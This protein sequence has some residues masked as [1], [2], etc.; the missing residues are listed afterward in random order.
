MRLSK[1]MPILLSKNYYYYYFF[2][3]GFYLFVCVYLDS[4]KWKGIVGLECMTR[5]KM[6]LM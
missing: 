4:K 3:C 5:E 2:F 6:E 1:L